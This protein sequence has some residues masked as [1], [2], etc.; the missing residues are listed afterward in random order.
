MLMVS[1]SFILKY[2]ILTNES[3]GII[4]GTVGAVGNLGGICCAIIFRYNGVNYSKV[5]W[6]I[7][8]LCISMN[9]AVSWIRP[10]PRGQIGGR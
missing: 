8:V 2:C 1:Y 3:L 4:S 9:L 7:G 10:V 6:I 5:F